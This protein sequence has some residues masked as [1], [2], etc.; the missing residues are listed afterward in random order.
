MDKRSE[1]EKIAQEERSTEK[2]KNAKDAGNMKRRK[3]VYGFRKRLFLCRP[4]TYCAITE[5]E[6]GEK[7]GWKENEKERE[8]KLS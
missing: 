8:K 2:S 5:K 7:R 3:K 4:D 1:K 6:R